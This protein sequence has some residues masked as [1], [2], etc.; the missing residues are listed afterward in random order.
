MATLRTSFSNLKLSGMP[1]INLRWDF[2][3]LLALFRSEHFRSQFLGRKGKSVPIRT[4]YFTWHGREGV[5]LSYLLRDAIV[6]LESAVVSAVHMEAVVRD[7]LTREVLEATLNPFSLPERG[8]AACVYNGLPSLIDP[9]FALEKRDKELWGRMRAFYREVRNPLFHAYEIEGRDAE[10]VWQCLEFLWEGFQWLNSWH[11]IEVFI[12][13][14]PVQWKPEA[15]RIMKEIPDVHENRV[16]QIAP[17][18][19]LPGGRDHIA[20]L[21]KEMRHV[22]IEDVLGLFLPSEDMVDVTAETENGEKV[23]LEISAA[24]AMKLLGFLA[25][26]REKRGWELPDRLW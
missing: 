21:P 18:V 9:D 12:E 3:K 15:V 13:E 10:P 19:E 16:R 22:A 2:N 7:L 4:H 6:S 17:P 20:Y 1:I 11:A 23:K 24:A 5:L 14:G 8:T 25:L 26:A